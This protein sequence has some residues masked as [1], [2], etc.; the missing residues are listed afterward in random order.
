MT[1][2]K[3]LKRLVRAR[4]AK[5]GEWCTAGAPSHRSPDEGGILDAS[6]RAKCRDVQLFVLR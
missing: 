5:T 1:D 2:H 6:S 4:I 3:H